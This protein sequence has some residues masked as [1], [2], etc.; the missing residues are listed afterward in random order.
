[1]SEHGT[2]THYVKGCRCDDCRRANREYARRRDRHLRH[3]AYGLEQPAAK[4][5][6]ATET[7]KHLEW[8][9]SWGIGLRTVS[10]RTGI[11]RSALQEIVNGE[12]RKVLV[13]TERKVLNVLRDTRHPR[14]L[15]DASLTWKRI[16]WLQ[17]QGWSKARIARELGYTSPALQ[18][19]GD[20]ITYRL[21]Q[22]VEQLVRKVLAA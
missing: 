5:V 17:Q 15:V 6:D 11:G 3:V 9:R 22:R 18:F 14:L 4:Y 8:L 7:R 13:D 10:Q 12:T 20:R 19:D 1:M 21:E 16:A 2:R